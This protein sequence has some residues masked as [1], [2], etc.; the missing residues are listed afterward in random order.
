MVYLAFC[1]LQSSIAISTTA[2]AVAPEGNVQG[3]A[4]LTVFVHIRYKQSCALFYGS[5]WLMPV[6]NRLQFVHLWCLQLRDTAHLLSSLVLLLQPLTH[7][8]SSVSTR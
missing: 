3:R 5:E 2:D 6:L 7:L 4:A 8:Y 1:A